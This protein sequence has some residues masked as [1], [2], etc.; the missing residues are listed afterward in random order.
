MR[1][2]SIPKRGSEVTA[3]REL[4]TRFHY[5]WVMVAACCVVASSYG[6]FFSFGVFLKPLQ[7]DLGG[8]RALIS[9]V[10]SGHLIVEAI[11]SIVLGK[12]TDRHGPRLAVSIG[13]ILL[14]VGLLLCSRARTLP[15]FYAAYMVAS[16]GSGMSW[17]PT[18]ATVQRW[19]GRHG[20]AV[21]LVTAGLGAGALVYAPL[22]SYLISVY[23]WQACFAIIGIGT[24]AVMLACAL[25]LVRSPEDRGLMPYGMK[26]A[27]GQTARSSC[28]QSRDGWTVHE[29][30][31]SG[32]FYGLVIISVAAVLPQQTIGVHLVPFATDM[33]IDKTL[34]A[35]AIGLV[36][37]ISVIGRITMSMVSDRIGWVRGITICCG[38]CALTLLWLIF[39]DNS[40]MLYVFVLV[41]G[42]FY[43]GKV[44]LIPGAT[45]HFFGTRAL[46]EL[47][48]IVHALS[49]SFAALGPFLGGW[50]YDVSGSY[51]LVF[52]MCGAM[53]G[54][55]AV[56][57]IGLKPPV[58]QSSI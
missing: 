50:I 46:G 18:I 45:A 21:G 20:M 10:Q 35:S 36:G 32:A 27:L 2:P 7:L 14:G 13:A 11:S 42:Y 16:F 48:A 24:S 57:S 28:P 55:A 4:S 6:I 5:G 39:T 56:I 29:T 9:S 58:K 22:C 51:S 49:M 54:L 17:S 34:A 8:S 1:G 43:G 33:G 15:E 19:F 40:W 53:W 44:P 31:R 26:N 47:T 37:A 12:I 30:L 41:Y 23:G 38:A 52:L 3:I 25:L